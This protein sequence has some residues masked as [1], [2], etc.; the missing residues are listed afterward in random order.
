MPTKFLMAIETEDRLG[1]IF[2]EK[3]FKGMIL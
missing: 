2:K 3:L 1:G